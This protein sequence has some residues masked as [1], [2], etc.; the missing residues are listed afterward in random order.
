MGTSEDEMKVLTLLELYLSENKLTDAMKLLK[1]RK[2]IIKLAHMNGWEVANLIAERTASK[3][4][5]WE[6]YGSKR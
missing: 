5:K 1:W 2:K 4:G 3:L 6:G